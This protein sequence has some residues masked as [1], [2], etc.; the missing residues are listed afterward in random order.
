M[1]DQKMPR[2]ER[3]VLEARDKFARLE[4]LFHVIKERLEDDCTYEWLLVDLGAATAAQYAVEMNQIGQ[5]RNAKQSS[6]NE[7]IA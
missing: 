2:V 6:Q 1:P 5:Q 4:A 3:A 7:V